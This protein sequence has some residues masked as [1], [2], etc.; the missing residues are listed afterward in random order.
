MKKLILLFMVVVLASCGTSVIV[1]EELP[2]VE[3]IE[4]EVVVPEVVEEVLEV[5][6][7]VV[8]EE[9]QYRD[10]FAELGIDSMERLFIERWYERSPSQFA[11]FRYLGG[12]L[13]KVYFN[14]GHTI[15]VTTLEDFDR[16]IQ[17]LEQMEFAGQSLSKV[18]S[19]IT[20][21]ITRVNV[22]NQLASPRISNN[23]L[24][25]SKDNLTLEELK[26][27]YLLLMEPF[28]REQNTL[29]ERGFLNSAFDRKGN[30][31][32][33]SVTSASSSLAFFQ[34][35]FWSSVMKEYDLLDEEELVLLTREFEVELTYFDTSIFLQNLTLIPEKTIDLASLPK[36]QN[37]NIDQR[38]FY[39]YLGPD[40]PSSV[41][42]IE[43]NG[44]DRRYYERLTL[45]AG[46]THP[47]QCP[48][49][50]NWEI[51][52]L[53]EVH[54]FTAYFDN[55]DPIEFNVK[56]NVSAEKAQELITP[57]VTI[58]G[59]MPSIMLRG[60]QGVL[61]IDGEGVVWGGPYHGYHT[62]LFNCGSCDIYQ[63]DGMRG[64]ILHELA[65]ASLDQGTKRPDHLTGQREVSSLGLVPLQKWQQASSMDGSHISNYAESVPEFEDLA[66]TI[67][68]YVASRYYSDRLS[69]MTADAL[70][71]FLPNRFALL[72][73]VFDNNE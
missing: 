28:V 26:A 22:V 70:R 67:L 16:S 3:V 23:V 57:I 14:D 40:D 51:S 72:D 27:V 55:N 1:E 50:T 34:E 7:E 32:D 62:T 53:Y 31:S 33:L 37:P 61:L 13:H 19:V 54:Q 8:I 44:I 36:H 65:H 24:T 59:Q 6:E 42:R 18:P 60:L 48:R 2:Q 17:S 47:N 38:V 20:R 58:Y 41:D 12:M 9:P 25:V 15:D 68:V 5:I 4:P 71:R 11:D 29:L 39:K 35:M 66:E 73:E 49:N 52:S 30:D 21:D 69:P 63:F 43:Y 45:P 10:S 46:C 56:N 64:L